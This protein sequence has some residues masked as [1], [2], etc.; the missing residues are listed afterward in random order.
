[1][2]S[3]EALFS[4]PKPLASVESEAGFSFSMCCCYVG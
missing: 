4:D 3:G 1:M 2:D